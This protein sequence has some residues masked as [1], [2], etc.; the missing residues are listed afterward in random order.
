MAR[1]CEPPPPRGNASMGAQR[2]RSERFQTVHITIYSIYYIYSKQSKLCIACFDAP[3]VEGS[4]PDK[5][6]SQ[7][8]AD[9]LQLSM[10]DPPPPPALP[11]PL[12]S[13]LSTWCVAWCWLVHNDTTPSAPL[14]PA[15]GWRGPVPCGVRL[16]LG[17]VTE[18]GGLWFS[19]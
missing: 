14:M 5:N 16:C 11:T 19:C 12:V 15:W 13:V 7:G 18:E 8:S 1:C 6:S 3:E 2:R 10:Q 4:A 9:M 17:A